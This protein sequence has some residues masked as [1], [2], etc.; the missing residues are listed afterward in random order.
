MAVSAWGTSQAPGLQRSEM[1]NVNYCTT[2]RALLPC[3]ECFTHQW[4]KLL[5]ISLKLR[6]KYHLETC[7]GTAAWAEAVIL[8]ES[9]VN[10]GCDLL[11]AWCVIT[12]SSSRPLEKQ[13]RTKGRKS[14]VWHTS[15]LWQTLLYNS[16]KDSIIS[17]ELS[18]YFIVL[19]MILLL[20][21][22]P[23]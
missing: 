23:K 7:Q 9:P 16:P 17:Y 15:V 1:P 10:K 3:M 11:F 22:L 13:I 21:C 4:L 12:W 18:Y 5:Y 8:T 20:K 14:S 2:E 19:D 6:W